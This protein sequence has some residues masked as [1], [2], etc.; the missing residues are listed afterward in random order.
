M[1]EARSGLRPWSNCKNKSRRCWERRWAPR[2][3]DGDSHP[4]RT[5]AGQSAVEAVR[6]SRLL[7]AR[8]SAVIHEATGVGELTEAVQSGQPSLRGQR[9]DLGPVAFDDQGVTTDED[10]AHARLAH[11]GK[12]GGEILS[13]PRKKFFH[14]ELERAGRRLDLPPRGIVRLA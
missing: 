5:A 8:R 13:I 10:R 11:S 4:D 7:D 3:R 6:S 12:R 1:A 2:P 14:F 9:H